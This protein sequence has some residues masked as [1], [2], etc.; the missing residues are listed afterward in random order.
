MNKIKLFPFTKPHYLGQEIYQ[1][2]SFNW[3]PDLEDFNASISDLSVLFKN[4]QEAHH[5]LKP[6]LKFCTCSC[7]KKPNSGGTLNPASPPHFECRLVR[8]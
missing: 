3:N 5:Q 1:E 2:G 6:N 8:K 4:V 7:I